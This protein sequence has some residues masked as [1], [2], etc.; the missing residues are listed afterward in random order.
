MAKAANKL[1]ARSVATLSEPGRHSDGGGL[2]LQVSPSGA[3]SW[4]FMFKRDGKRRELGLGSV[5]E[6]PLAEARQKAAEMRRRL[7]EGEDPRQARDRDAGPVVPTFGVFADDWCASTEGG[8]RNEK[9]KA[10]IRMTL[11]DA[12]CASIRGKAVDA[13]TTDDVLAILQPI[14][15]E[16]SETASRLRGRI[17]KVLDAAKAKGLRQGENPARWRGHLALLLP[18]RNK[19]QRGHHPAMPYKDLPAFLARL[20]TH[21]SPSALALEFAVLTVSRTQEAIAARWEEI[22]LKNA[23]WTIPAGRMKR[24]R[25]HRVPLVGRALEILTRMEAIRDREFVFPGQKAGR[26]LSNM[27]LLMVLRRMEIE[28]ATTHGFRSCFRDWAGDTTEFQREI[29][30]AAM[31]HAVGD[32]TEQAYRR[33]DALQKRRA[34]MTLWDAFCASA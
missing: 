15:L 3:K 13:I 21:D 22:D 17:E 19:L 29:A 26:P 12:Y 31:S 27:A 28:N 14:W 1:T 11:G 7:L 24:P 2:Y 30:E 18:K 10:Q 4:L 20:R 32:M 33:G 6:V 34:L 23:V 9:H 8:F 5:R 16:K 25:E